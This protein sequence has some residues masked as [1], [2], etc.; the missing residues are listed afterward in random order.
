M[1]VRRIGRCPA[2]RTLSATPSPS[3]RPLLKGPGG[4]GVGAG[5]LFRPPHPPTSEN[6]SGKKMK[7]IKARI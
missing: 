7:F 6:F 2:S 4:G 3:A 1:R 5:R